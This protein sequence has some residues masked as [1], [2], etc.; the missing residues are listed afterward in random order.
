MPR[1]RL[2]LLHHVLVTV[3]VALIATA[4]AAATAWRSAQHQSASAATQVSA[5]IA[6]AA[7]AGLAANDFGT[8]GGYDRGD[9]LAGLQP[10][11]RSGALARVKL[12]L[13]EGGRARILVS[14][15]ARLEGTA[16]DTGDRPIRTLEPAAP[17]SYAVPDD[18]AHRYE[19]DRR[20]R[21][22]E[23]FL[24]FRDAARNTM[25]LELYVPVGG[26]RTV[27]R[28]VAAQL[29][30]LLAG[31]LAVA[32][33]TL[34]ITV[35][36]TRRTRRSAVH[37]AALAELAV[38]ASDRERRELAQRLHDG[39][40]QMLAAASVALSLD[41]NTLAHGLVRDGLRQLRTLTDDVVPDAIAGPELAGRL[42]AMLRAAVPDPIALDVRV[43]RRGAAA[44]PGD[45]Q[46]LLAARCA[47]ELVRNAVRHAR[48]GRITVALD[49]DA[50][51]HLTVDDDG[52]GF[53]PRH[54]P[55][56]GVPHPAGHLGLVLITQAVTD[57]GG[58]L[59]L[60]SGPGAGCTATISLPFRDA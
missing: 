45:D 56:D 27:L 39:P 18:E 47:R 15:E 43:T 48:P 37:R 51:L 44:D 55:G 1:L 14:D 60:R 34:P 58:T 8:P 28:P 21:L 7:L 24:D 42:P 54:L 2:V 40:I 26:D 6:D 41:T 49:I 19:A 36:A 59:T 52:A 11:L 32:V 35:A 20:G 30:L 38:T 50:T 16:R 46:A 9:V 22:M 25:S 23:V 33:A 5:A 29:P 12:W 3:A 10:F 13:V 53:D 17:R 4:G 57:A 31:S